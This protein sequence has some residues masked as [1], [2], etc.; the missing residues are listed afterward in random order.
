VSAP[1]RRLEDVHLAQ[2]RSVPARRCE[3]CAGAKPG[4]P[5]TRAPGGWTHDAA[6]RWRRRG[7]WPAANASTRAYELYAA[8]PGVTAILPVTSASGSR[9]VAAIREA[10][11]RYGGGRPKYRRRQVGLRRTAPPSCGAPGLRH[12]PSCRV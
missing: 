6:S 10:R 8:L 3:V 5:P 12:M 9:D 1:D 2:A 4:P 7:V 11:L